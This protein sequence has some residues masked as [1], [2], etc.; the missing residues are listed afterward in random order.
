MAKSTNRFFC[1]ITKGQEDIAANTGLNFVLNN[2]SSWI[3]STTDIDSS[4][5]PGWTKGADFIVYKNAAYAIY[6]TF[7]F[8]EEDVMVYLCKYSPMGCDI[9]K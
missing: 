9:V 3:P 5:A 8:P 7:M 2:K 4:L 1:I 6:K